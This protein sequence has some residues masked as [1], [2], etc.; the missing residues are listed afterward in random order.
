VNC[1]VGW[2]FSVAFFVVV[3]MYMPKGL[4]PEMVGPGIVLFVRTV[5][6]K[7]VIRGA[8]V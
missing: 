3:R 1:N 5:G 8:G 6:P 2:H 7:A 4:Y